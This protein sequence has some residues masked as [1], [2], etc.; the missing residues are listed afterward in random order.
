[1]VFSNV[2]VDIAISCHLFQLFVFSKLRAKVSASITNISGLAVTALISYTASC[3]ASD[4][5]LY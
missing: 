3:V 5:S 1:M 4:L 2:I